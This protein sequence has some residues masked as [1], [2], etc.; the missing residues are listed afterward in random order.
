MAKFK[1]KVSAGNITMEAE[2]MLIE[3][4][5]GKVMRYNYFDLRCSCPCASCIDEWTGNKI[6]DDST[7]NK[8]V[9]PVTSK[10]TGNYALSIKW[11]DG[12]DT[13]LYTFQELRA[14][15]PSTLVE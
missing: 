5:D 11:D 2:S 7:I 9:K 1:R 3:W 6:L 8:A 10:Y 15:Y 13:G 12:H 14:T 4:S